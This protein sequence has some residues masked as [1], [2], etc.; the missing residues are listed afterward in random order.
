MSRGNN[1]TCARLNIW[2]SH[3]DSCS[4]KFKTGVNSGILNPHLHL[5]T[6]KTLQ[7]RSS[8][9]LSLARWTTRLSWQEASL[10][11]CFYNTVY[12]NKIIHSRRGSLGPSTVILMALWYVATWGGLVNTVMVRVK[13]FPGQRKETEERP[14]MQSNRIEGSA[15][16]KQCSQNLRCGDLSLPFC[17]NKQTLHCTYPWIY[18]QMVIKHP[19]TKLLQSVKWGLSL[20]SAVAVATYRIVKWH[21]IQSEAWVLFIVSA[22]PQLHL[23][24]NKYLWDQRF[25][26]R[27]CRRICVRWVCPLWR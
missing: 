15:V 27:L 13:L 1:G 7:R 17:K 21:Y 20:I 5:E 26:L 3:N 8:W 11:D 24:T 10:E 19:V 6:R 4:S 2:F 16:T 14:I 12:R 22:E 23:R 18:Q 9:H 25:A